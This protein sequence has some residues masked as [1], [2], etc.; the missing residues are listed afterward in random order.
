MVSLPL[1]QGW[2]TRTTG[3]YNSG[4]FYSIF[5]CEWKKI[6]I[7]LHQSLQTGG[8]RPNQT[9]FVRPPQCFTNGISDCKGS[10]TN[11]DYWLLF[12]KIRRAGNPEL[13]CS[14]GLFHSNTGPFRQDTVWFTQALPSSG[15]TPRQVRVSVWPKLLLYLAPVVSGIISVWSLG[16]HSQNG[17]LSVKTS[18]KCEAKG[19]W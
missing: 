5:P 13:H 10:H 19:V 8:P 17:F 4:N 1:Q 12:W 14:N 15:V 2:I 3:E 6:S 18:S 9:A 11:P 7:N 16:L